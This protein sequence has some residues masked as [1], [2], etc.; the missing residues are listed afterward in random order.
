MEEMNKY[1]IVLDGKMDEPVWDTVPEYSGFTMVNTLDAGKLQKPETFFRI[2][3]CE[4]RIYIGFKCMDPGNMAHVEATKD[5]RGIWGTQNMEIFLAPLGNYFEV[6][7]FIVTYSG[8][9]QA[10]YYS[11]NCTIKPDP[12]APD[13]KHAIYSSE[14]YWS[15]EVEI[16][17]SSFYMT[18]ND[19]WNDTWLVNLARTRIGEGRK[20]I[21]SS[22]SPVKKGFL[23]PE[24]F[25]SISGFPM[26]P[27]ADALRISSASAEMKTKTDSGYRGMMT[28]KVSTF[29]DD[30][31]EFTSDHSETVTLSLPAGDHEFKIPCFIN[32]LN[33]VDVSLSLKRLSDG[34]VFKR[35]YP[36]RF[37][38]EPLK[39]KL[40][41]PEYRDNFYPGQDYTKIVGTAI[42]ESA[43][44]L[45]LEGAGIPTQTVTVEPGETFQFDTPDFEIGEAWLTASTANDEIKK[46]IRR[47]APSEHTMTWISGGNMILDGEP[48][49][50]RV[51]YGGPGGGRCTVAFDERF[52]ADDFHTTPKMKLLSVQPETL[53]KGSEFTG[54]ALK[55]Q[56]PSDQM[57]ALLD[58][59]IDENKDKN[60]GFYYL[61]DEPECRGVS[62]V[63]LRHMYEHIKERDPYHVVMICSR[64]PAAFVECADWFQAHPFLNP[65]N[66]KDGSRSYDRPIHTMGRYVDAIVN[67]N[68]S[69][70]CMGFLPTCFAYRDYNLAEDHPT[71]DEIV[72]HTWAAMMHGGKTLWPYVYDGLE[73]RPDVYYGFRYL[74][75]SFAALEQL[76]L[77]G[78]RTTLTRSVDAE[79]VLYDN[80]DEKMFV[81]VNYKQEPQTVTLEGLS[82][83]WHS[84]CHG[85]M[86]TGNTFELKPLETV[87]GTSKV[88]DTG[89]PSYAETAAII[90]K[91]EKERISRG[92][93]LYE[94]SADIQVTATADRRVGLQCFR[95]FDGSY[96]NLGVKL[97]GENG[98]ALELNISKVAPKFNKVVIHGYNLDGMKLLAG[99]GETWS[100]LPVADKKIEQYCTTFLLAETVSPDALRLEFVK[101]KV[102]VYEVELF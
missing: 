67:L 29:S 23:E 94:R 83:T 74:F 93:L 1:G 66:E 68:R 25:R 89:L 61:T 70:K 45:T 44:T 41:Q 78:K 37:T 58:A 86:I 97:F 65:T 82:G 62:D 98:S 95:L 101:E 64:E 28:V 52:L 8:R 99:D 43:V 72:A 4:D 53:I 85:E 57:I 5:A 2:L 16:P 87:I 11:E 32:E 34:K 22:W 7:Q 6:Y 77:F 88:K 17:L 12:Y 80:G 3:H 55:D 18:P 102:E 9:T 31:Y 100:E 84:F 63:Y 91:L 21:L 92:S 59:R 42:A 13:W 51:F 79:A 47:V 50:S 96:E 35:Y 71:F 27:L 40:S 19:K 24:K 90:E 38:Y 69:E 56:Y 48:V 81:L 30:D 54:E 75:A 73:D 26:R 49:L 60:F 33:K 15:A 14:D 46:K 39:V 36:V 76:V 10:F 20:V